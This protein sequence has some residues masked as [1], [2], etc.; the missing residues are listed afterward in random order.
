MPKVDSPVSNTSVATPEAPP[1]PKSTTNW[2]ALTK[3]GLRPT[4]IYCQAYAD[5]SGRLLD[6]VDSSCHSRLVPKT[7][8]L[9]NHLRGGHGGQFKIGL[10]K[11]DKSAS[12]IWDELAIAG[13]EAVDFR[14]EVCGV[15]LRFNLTS[16]TNHLRSHAGKTRQA[17]QEMTRDNPGS[18]GMFSI[19]LGKAVGESQLEDLDELSDSDED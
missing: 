4:V 3:A 8:S 7:D 19:K 1:A 16:F 13:I 17:Y 9:L 6:R 14:C 2:A 18:I 11:S 5:R 15:E 10:R 12:P